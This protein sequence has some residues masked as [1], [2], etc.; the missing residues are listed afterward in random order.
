[1][2]KSF[3]SF[4]GGIHPRDGKELAA[5]KAIEEM[6]LPK[7]VVIP[8]S[9]HIGAPC[10]PTV[11][12]G[13]TVKRGQLIGTTEA[14]M[15]ADIHASVSGKVK[16]IDD[17]P[18]SGRITCPAIVI[19]SDGEDAW[20]EGLPLSRD[21]R[22]MSR[23]EILEAV[24]SAGIVGMGGATFPAH[25]KLK[26]SKP[27]DVIIINGAECEPYLTADYRLMLEQPQQVIEGTEILAK[28]LDV[29]TCYIGIEDN[30]PK[31]IEALQNAAKGHECIEIA[32]L[33]TKYPQGAEKMLIRVIA[34]RE[35]PM[36]GLPMDVGAVVQNA[37]TVAAIYD[38]VVKGLPLTERITTVSGDAISQPKNLRIRIGTSYRDVIAYCGGFSQQPDKLLA[39]GPMMGMAQFSLD[40][41]VMKGSSGILALTKKITEHGEESPCIRCGRCVKACPMGL[42]P[43]ML[44]ILGERSAFESARDEYGLMNCIECGSCTYVCPAKRNIV[45][46]IRHSKS[47]IRSIMLKAKAKAQEKE[48]KK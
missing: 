32:P 37:G 45:Q 5:D 25:I 15:H 20:V 23:E 18:H 6:P 30:K 47:E 44:S 8:L 19:E 35:V 13:D 36:G 46:Y 26:P 38:A 7:E 17:M 12:V 28:L 1:M 21:W 40:V 48:A 2:L 11:K 27:I 10:T 34:G 43:S 33:K 22:A 31:A 9:Q 42:V 3:S 29:K 4:L 41:P 24:Q 39:G 16:K 14:F